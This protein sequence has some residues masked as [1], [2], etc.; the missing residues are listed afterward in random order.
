MARFHALGMAIKYKKPEYF[1]VLKKRSEPIE[2][3]FPNTDNWLQKMV[4][5]MME[6]PDIAAHIDRCRTN[7]E[8][9][10][11][12]FRTAVSVEPWS[13]IIHTDFWVNNIMFHRSEDGRVDDVKFVDFQNYRFFS[14]L[15]ELVFY[16]FS[17]TNDEVQDNN[18]DELIDL[19][20]ETLL[21]VLTR[22]GCET[23]LFARDKFDMQLPVDAKI[24][25]VHLCFMLKIL[26][27]DTQDT[28]DYEIKDV[29]MSYQGNQA[30]LR[31]LRKIVLYFVERNWL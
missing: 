20:H 21:I 4:D 17:S 19:Y 14:P 26:T 24:E 11:P 29:F 30:L 1:K 6:D 7:L 16:L 10:L 5:K 25:F 13:T 3:Y 12:K 31:R 18:I 28:K 8:T 9:M 27:L 2:G 23:Q 22:M 15:R